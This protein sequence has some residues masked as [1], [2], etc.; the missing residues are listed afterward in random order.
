M[1]C[2]LADEGTISAPKGTSTF[3]NCCVAYIIVSMKVTT[4]KRLI[5]TETYML[6]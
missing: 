5:L 2:S 3:D 4:H 1:F 6:N